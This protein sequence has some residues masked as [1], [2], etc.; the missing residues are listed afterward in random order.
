MRI[1]FA[2]GIGILCLAVSG[3][4]LEAG[5]S[6]RNLPAEQP[7]ASDLPDFAVVSIKRLSDPGQSGALYTPDGLVAHGPLLTVIRL[8]YSRIRSSDEEFVG[9]PDWVRA[10][11]FDIEAKVD[12]SEVGRFQKL[13][14]AEK[15]LMVQKLLAS[16]FKLKVHEE[17]R[18]QAGYDLVVIK[19]GLKVKASDPGPGVTLFNGHEIKAQGYAIA[20]LG[21]PLSQIVGRS[22]QD[23]TGL[24][25]NY[26]FD[27]NW[28]PQIAGDAAYS[29][30]SIFS[31]LEE[32]LG[33]K[34]LPA[35]HK[36][37]VLIVDHAEKPDIN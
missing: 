9:V 25:G 10:D 3:V 32:Q 20:N 16:R 22:V 2:G 1:K 11:R 4:S 27:M 29:G 24:S 35:K 19:S 34:L 18:E 5:F 14:Y 15:A 30:P 13:T 6:Q 36:V 31:A 28:A 21:V 26:S 33:L 12:P 17:P 37:M 8:A 7:L 23:K